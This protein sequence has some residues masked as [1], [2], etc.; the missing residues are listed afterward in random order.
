M[1]CQQRIW[2]TSYQICLFV[3]SGVLSLTEKAT[4]VLCFGYYIWKDNMLLAGFTIGLGLPGLAVQALSA[5]WYITDGERRKPLLIL[6]HLLHLGIFKR[7][8]DCVQSLRQLQVCG[9][10]RGVVVMQ[11][12]D[13]SAL[14]LLDALLHSLPQ[15]L[16]QSWVLLTTDVGLLSPVGLCSGLC[17]LALAWALVLFGRACSLIRPGHVPMP[18]VAVVCLLLWRVGMLG[19]RITSLV[20]FFRAFTW[21]TCGI[22]GFHWLA[23]TFWLVS[24]QTDICRSVRHWRLFNCILGAVHVFVFLNVKVGRSRYRMAAFYLV[25]MLENTVL[26]LAASDVFSE[27]SW[28]SMSVPT[29][30]FCSFSVG[31]ISVV[32]FYHFLHPKSTEISQNPCLCQADQDSDETD[33]SRWPEEKTTPESSGHRHGTFSI[34][35]VVPIQDPEPGSNSSSVHPSLDCKHHHSL[36][37]RLALKTGDWDKIYSAYEGGG[38]ATLLGMNNASSPEAPDPGAEASDKSPLNKREHSK[39]SG[40]P[41]I[42]SED[43]QDDKADVA[44]AKESSVSELRRDGAEDRSALA[45]G[46]AQNVCPAESGT[47]L[48]FSAEPAS[49]LSGSNT[50]LDRDMP[51]ESLA[52]LSPISSG[53]ELHWAAK[54]FL[55]R[56]PC[57]TSTP[58]Q[59]FTH[60]G[61]VEPRPGAARRQLVHFN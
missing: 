25:M 6:L 13:A 39:G 55:N 27:A 8:W 1:K 26:L 34:T 20:F 44:N 40:Y 38:V 21:W 4:V 37:I 31:I 11:Q 58:K 16:L 54:E 50:Y 15:S 36:L 52:R 2:T 45:D 9:E 14:C 35:G 60:M 56:E 43:K 10:K 24:Q 57:Y 48:Y 12:A 53:R 47:T 33:P 7:F 5:K 18:P 41:Q 61:H 42:P 59:E 19:A 29:A 3:F 46:P 17:V 32:L 22:V 28:D 23:A 51:S 30:V 49:P